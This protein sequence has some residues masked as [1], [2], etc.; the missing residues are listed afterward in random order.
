SENGPKRVLQARLRVICSRG[1]RRRLKGLN[2]RWGKEQPRLKLNTIKIEADNQEGDD[3]PGQ[4]KGEHVA[5]VMSGDAPSRFSRGFDRR[6]ILLIGHHDNPLAPAKPG[7][8]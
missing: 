8:T 5:H 3:S 2:G 6:D 7:F 4:S 1:T